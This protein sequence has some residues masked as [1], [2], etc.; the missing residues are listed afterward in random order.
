MVRLLSLVLAFGVAAGFDGYFMK[1]KGRLA[2]TQTPITT[3]A[4]FQSVVGS[5]D[6]K[7]L[8]AQR[9]PDPPALFLTVLAAQPAPAA[10]K[11]RTPGR[12][13]WP[14]VPHTKLVAADSLVPAV[15][16]SNHRWASKVGR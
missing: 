9:R 10:R 7:S 15:S 3:P 4:T 12:Y 6:A 5:T 11:A 2:L 14:E 1:D 8:Q 13:S 16:I